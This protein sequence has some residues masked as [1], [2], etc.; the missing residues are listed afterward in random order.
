M[1][2]FCINRGKG[3]GGWGVPDKSSS[4]GTYGDKE[5]EG[6]GGGGFPINP[7]GSGLGREGGIR[8]SRAF[9]RA[10]TQK[11]KKGKKKRGG[12]WLILCG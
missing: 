6:V 12:S 11:G 5:R 8:F 1:G 7:M 4:S 9:P 2:K 3:R 10:A